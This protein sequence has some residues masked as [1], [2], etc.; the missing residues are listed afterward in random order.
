MVSLTPMELEW[1]PC[2]LC[3][4]GVSDPVLNGE[5]AYQPHSPVYTIVRCQS[6]D[7]CYL[8]PR[9]NES[10][11]VQ[12]YSSETYQELYHLNE[13]RPSALRRAWHRYSAMLGSDPWR[14]SQRPGRMLDVGCGF[15]D[16]MLSFARKG[17]DVEGV[18]TSAVAVDAA[19]RRGLVVHAGA[20]EDLDLPRD[21]YDLITMRHVLEHVHDPVALLQRT[22]TL[23]KPDG[24]LIVQVP[25][26]ASAEARVFGKRWQPLELPRHLSHFNRSTLDNVLVRAGFAVHGIKADPHPG[27]FTRSL[28]RTMRVPPRAIVNPLVWAVL[29]PFKSLAAAGLGEGSSLVARGRRT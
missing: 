18:D 8:N 22:H 15:G 1:T 4:S 27:S 20:L 24:E 11:M 23:L 19:N 17:W 6:C 16:L 12:Y 29:F 28:A 3:G 5:D 10:A 14:T 26:I 13:K 25:N 2:P 7:F 21:A 9:P